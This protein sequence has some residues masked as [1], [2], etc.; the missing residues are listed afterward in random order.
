MRRG[1]GVGKRPTIC[2]LGRRRTKMSLVVGAKKFDFWV[3]GVG[4]IM[5][6]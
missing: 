4:T 1:E 5:A 6:L 3:V 2:E